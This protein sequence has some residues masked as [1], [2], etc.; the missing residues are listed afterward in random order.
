MNRRQLFIAILLTL[1][2]GLSTAQNAGSRTTTYTPDGHKFFYFNP[3]STLS[4]MVSLKRELDI[5]LLDLGFSLAAIP[6]A[7]LNDFDRVI[8]EVLP[9]FVLMPKWYY[10]E[11]GK[12]L[13]FEP[14]LVPVRNGRTDY[15]KV[16]LTSKQSNISIEDLDNKTLATTTMGGNRD[17]LLNEALF[18]QFNKDIRRVNVV[19]TPKDS[20]ALFALILGQVEVAL[21][22]EDNWKIIGKINRVA[23]KS[24]KV[25]C[26]TKP[27]PLPILCVRKGTI[28]TDKIAM[29]KGLFENV[30]KENNK[31]MEMLQIDGWQKISD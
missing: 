8:N 1:F 3:D 17:K 31:F 28:S 10:D 19:T 21:V 25:L 27:I 12:D 29:L 15:Q 11:H 4:N 22:G 9:E 6:F 23:D 16:L 14:L 2:L 20:D 5:F 13:D 7:K 18:S 24:V 30:G 26:R